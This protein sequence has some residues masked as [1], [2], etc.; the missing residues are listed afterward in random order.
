MLP[1]QNSEADVLFFY[2]TGQ[3]SGRLVALT[4]PE[5]GDLFA[6]N[7]ATATKIG[8]AALL[9][10]YYLCGGKACR[11][12][13]FRAR[14]EK[15]ALAI[16]GSGDGKSTEEHGKRRTSK[17]RGTGGSGDNSFIKYLQFY[18]HAGGSPSA[19]SAAAGSTAPG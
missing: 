2:V 7:D 16:N 15:A 18:I 6:Y 13:Q 1:L 12:E 14:Q 11:A 4:N 19:S 10:L 5:L 8:R 17:G 3:T 9:S